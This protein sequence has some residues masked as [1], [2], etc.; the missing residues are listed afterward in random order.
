M[1][2]LLTVNYLDQVDFS[3]KFANSICGVFISDRCIT[4]KYP[5]QLEALQLMMWKKNNLTLIILIF[6]LIMPDK[7]YPTQAGKTISNKATEAIMLLTVIMIT[8]PLIAF[9]LL[10]RSTW[11]NKISNISGNSKI[12]QNMIFYKYA[13]R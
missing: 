3:M 7:M 13:S 12:R 1:L 9:T 5:Q 10:F 2:I 6:E 11:N 8:S 4:T